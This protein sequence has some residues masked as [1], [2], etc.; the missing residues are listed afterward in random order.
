MDGESRFKKQ[1]CK[2]KDMVFFEEEY[3][4]PLLKYKVWWSGWLWGKSDKGISTWQTH[5]G[6]N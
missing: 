1:L 3:N 2:C 6:G 5:L 4:L